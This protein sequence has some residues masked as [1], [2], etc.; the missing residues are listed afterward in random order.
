MKVKK[1]IRILGID[2]APFSRKDKDVLVIG[3]IY[4]GGNYLDGLISFHVKNDGDDATE[5]I[6]KVVKKTKHNQ[7]LRCIMI[8]GICLAGFNIIDIQ[9]VWKKTKIPVIVIMRK[10]PRIKRFINALRKID[11]KR[12]ELVNKAGKISKFR[13]ENKKKKEKNFNIYV[14]LAGLS[15]EDAKRILEISCRNS[16]IP[17]PIRIAHIIGSGIMNGEGRG[18]A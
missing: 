7:Q 11:K 4:R 1:E 8:D 13:I 9:R 2:D 5:K 6:I 10:L 12:I 17:E 14:Q 16:N 15:L 18:K 3:T